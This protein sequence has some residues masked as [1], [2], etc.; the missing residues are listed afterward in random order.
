MRRGSSLP[1]MSPGSVTGGKLTAGALVALE[2]PALLGLWASVEHG[3]T[4]IHGA[5]A[6]TIACVVDRAEHVEEPDAA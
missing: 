3:G 5:F 1:G 2:A 4:A 6:Q